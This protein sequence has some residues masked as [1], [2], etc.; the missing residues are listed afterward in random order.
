MRLRRRVA[1]A[2]EVFQQTGRPSP[3]EPQ[4]PRRRPILPEVL[5]VAMVWTAGGMWVSSTPVGIAG[6]YDLETALFGYG[7]T[8]LLLS[9]IPLCW[10]LVRRRWRV[11]PL[12]RWTLVGVLVLAVIPASLAAVLS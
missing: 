10:A 6:G 1:Q 11:V 8:I 4:R 5:F 12:V 7:L 9:V 3:W 2:W